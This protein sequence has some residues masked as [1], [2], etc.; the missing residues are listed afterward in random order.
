MSEETGPEQFQLPEEPVV[1]ARHLATSGDGKRRSTWMVAVVCAAVLLAG[2]GVSL[3]LALE[4]HSEVHAATPPRHSS[5]PAPTTT[6][7][8]P[9]CPLSGLPAGG[10]QVPRHPAL[11]VKIDNYPAARPQSGLDKADIVFEEPVEGGITRLV[12]VFQCQS[13]GLIG[14][15]RS[16]RAVDASILDELSKPIFVHVG[17]IAPVL[18]IVRHANDFDENINNVG[19]PSQNPRGRYAPYDT[20]ISTSAGWGL[21]PSDTTPPAP[22]FT[23]S[24][25]TPSGTPANSVHIPYSQT[26]DVSWT[27]NSSSGLWELSYGGVPATVANGGQIGVAN[28]VIEKVHVTYGPWAENSQGALEVQSQ[29]TG[30]GQLTVLR[31]GIAVSGTWQRPSLGQAASL[32]GANGS[33]IPLAPGETWVEIVPSSIS[34]TTTAPA[35]ATGQ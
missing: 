17:G 30:S 15:I 5:A 35:A 21:E 24:P 34:V 31:N 20:Y 1:R 33:V 32:V 28:I 18:S 13:A 23:Y 8:G 22:I 4:S 16:A 3:G 19:P 12:A 11:A 14:P 29:L 27:W 2:A 25:T 9:P 10:G 26:N 6:P 7:T